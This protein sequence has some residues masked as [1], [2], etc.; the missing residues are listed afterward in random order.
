MPISLLVAH[1]P[2]AS[3]IA[4]PTRATESVEGDLSKIDED[5]R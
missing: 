4:S 3:P 2:G 1:L 5:A